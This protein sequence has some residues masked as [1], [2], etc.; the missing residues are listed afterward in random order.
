MMV[1]VKSS[2]AWG[3]TPGAPKRFLRSGVDR[4]NLSLQRCQPT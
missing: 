3:H 1:G 4:C 2:R